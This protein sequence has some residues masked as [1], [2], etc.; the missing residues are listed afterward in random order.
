MVIKKTSLSIIWKKA[1]QLAEDALSDFEKGFY[2]HRPDVETL[3]QIYVDDLE[4]LEELKESIL[5]QN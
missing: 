5:Q 2:N 4:D 3:H 1:L